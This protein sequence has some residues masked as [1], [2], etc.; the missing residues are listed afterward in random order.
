MP[1]WTEFQLE[2]LEYLRATEG[3]DWV[4]IAGE[5]GHTARACEQMARQL[6]IV[7]GP[8][9]RERAKVRRVAECALALE[10]T[11]SAAARLQSLK[12]AQVLSEL[13]LAKQIEL[14]KAEASTAPRY[15]YFPPRS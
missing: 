7:M 1:Q 4:F 10:S 6:D 15:K 13:S 12:S 11:R 14:A 2:D 5:I 9:A 3:R 8:E